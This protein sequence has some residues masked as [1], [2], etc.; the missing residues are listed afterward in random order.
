MGKKIAY[1]LLILVLA[2]C[3]PRMT[4]AG[5]L[6]LVQSATEIV[7]EAEGYDMLSL[8]RIYGP[9]PTSPLSLTFNVNATTGDV[10]Y[11]IDNGSVYLNKS[12]TLKWDQEHS[13]RPTTPGPC[14]PPAH[15]A[16]A[17]SHPPGQPP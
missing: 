6:T 13:I 7:M 5:S 16:R 11:S 1:F 17:R 10:S 9:D 3:A 4:S 12:I 2:A 14:R 8:G 15:W